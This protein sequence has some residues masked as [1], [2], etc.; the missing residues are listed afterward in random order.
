MSDTE[1]VATAG[2]SVLSPAPMSLA[3][4]MGLGLPYMSVVPQPKVQPA[5]ITGDVGKAAVGQ[6]DEP[7]GIVVNHRA[8]LPDVLAYGYRCVKPLHRDA[9]FVAS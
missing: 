1:G 7:V 9:L 6:H 3:G 2:A 4:P 5:L 8:Q